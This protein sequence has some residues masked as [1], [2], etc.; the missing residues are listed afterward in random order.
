MLGSVLILA[1][2]FSIAVYVIHY[3]ASFA[4]FRRL[5]A[6]EAVLE[7]GDDHFRIVSDAGATEVPWATVSELWRF[8]DFW[9]LFLSPSQFITFPLEDL[10]KDVQKL[11]L[12]R[13]KSHGAKVV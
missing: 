7:T 8:R 12:E 5:R 2:G 1:I 6:A 11:I 13:L 10:D 9:L 3:R 4:R